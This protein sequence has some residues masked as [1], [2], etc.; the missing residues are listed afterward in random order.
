MSRPGVIEKGSEL[1]LVATPCYSS[2]SL[3]LRASL[4]AAHSHS[5]SMLSSLD[6]RPR[7]LG[8][9]T[10]KLNHSNR[11]ASRCDSRR[12]KSRRPPH[13]HRPAFSD[14]LLV[15]HDPHPG[16]G[17]PGGESWDGNQ[18]LF[19]KCYPK[20]QREGM[21]SP[22]IHWVRM[23]S[24]IERGDGD[25]PGSGPLCTLYSSENT[26]HCPKNTTETN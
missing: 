21:V 11:S 5:K 20:Q 24:F 7:S 9:E 13:E 3:C 25:C 18:N 15:P 17:C 12:K 1:R 8:P 10:G 4:C 26:Q 16:K 14:K 22:V 2:L 19:Q 23:T 6:L